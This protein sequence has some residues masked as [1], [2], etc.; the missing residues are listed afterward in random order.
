MLDVYKLVMDSKYNPLKDL[1]PAQRFQI[2]VGLSFMWTTIF[3]V[4][5]GAWM[6]Y[7]ELLALHV[8]FALGFLVN[9]VT[10][11]GAKRTT[12]YRDQP[13]SDGT[14]RYSDIWGA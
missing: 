9:V 7:G 14:A 8:L 1:P 6:F 13:L 5:A 4:G 2:M 11:Y 12:T 10:F 3:C